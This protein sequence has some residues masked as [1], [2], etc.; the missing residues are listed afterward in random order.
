MMQDF[1]LIT[2]LLD[3]HVD[4]LSI[5]RATPEAVSAVIEATFELLHALQRRGVT[6]I[7]LWVANVMLPEQGKASA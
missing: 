4:G 1:F 6:H 5:I 2:E 7:D 3:D